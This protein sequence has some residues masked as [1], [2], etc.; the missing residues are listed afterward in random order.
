MAILYLKLSIPSI[1]PEIRVI[2]DSYS[3]TCGKAPGD[4][5]PLTSGVI[6]CLHNLPSSRHCHRRSTGT[7]HPRTHRGLPRPRIRDTEGASDSSAS[8]HITTYAGPPMEHETQDAP[9]TTRKPTVWIQRALAPVPLREMGHRGPE[10]PAR[11]KA[12]CA[13]GKDP[14]SLST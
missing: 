8:A 5:G 12:G 13:K 1:P 11:C 6:R 4:L 9:K 7:P 3:P 14:R 2:P 10:E